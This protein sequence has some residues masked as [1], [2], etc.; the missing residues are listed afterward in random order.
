MIVLIQEQ[1]RAPSEQFYSKMTQLLLRYQSLD[2]LNRQELRQRIADLYQDYVVT[3][4]RLTRQEFKSFVSQVGLEPYLPEPMP[5][6][7]PV[8]SHAPENWEVP[9]SGQANW[10]SY[11]K[12][13]QEARSLA[14]LDSAVTAA[15]LWLNW[16]SFPNREKFAAYEKRLQQETLSRL[17]QMLLSPKSSLSSSAFN[18]PNKSVVLNIL[19]QASIKDVYER[20]FYLEEFDLLVD[21]YDKREWRPSALNKNLLQE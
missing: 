7:A 19:N 20:D 2:E 5:E 3:Q 10:E 14:A 16:S 9:L 6:T 13:I 8:P 11:M 21:R 15:R 18:R 1:N 4:H 17:E 12:K